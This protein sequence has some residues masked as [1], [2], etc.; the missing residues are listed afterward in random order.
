MDEDTKLES[1]IDILPYNTKQYK[2]N[3]E[4]YAKAFLIYSVGKLSLLPEL[5]KIMPFDIIMK[6]LY[7]YA[8]QP[9]VIPDTN[10]IKQAIRDLDIYYSLVNNPTNSEIS[11]LSELYSTSPQNIKWIAEKVALSLDKPSPV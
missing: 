4:E 1:I 2:I 10:I 8:G 7:L 5:Y 11:K 3:E 9:L 6:L